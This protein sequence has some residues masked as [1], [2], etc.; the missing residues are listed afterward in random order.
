VAVYAYLHTPKAVSTKEDDIVAFWEKRIRRDGALSAYNA[1]A[2]SVS[3]VDASEAHRGAHL[4]GEALYAIQGV[5]GISTCDEQFMYGC[6]HQVV[7]EAILEDGP[8]VVYE[9]GKKC[10]GDLQCL[11]GIGHGVVMWYGYEQDMLTEAFEACS[12]AS[13]DNNFNGCVSGVFMEYNYPAFPQT[14]NTHLR[15][16]PPH[17][18]HEPCDTV[19]TE[20]APLCYYWQ[21]RLWKDSA[22]EEKDNTVIISTISQRCALLHDDRRRGCMGGIGP[23]TISLTAYNP[24]EITRLCNAIQGN[25]E[26]ITLCHAEAG[27]VL[28]GT[29]SK[30]A[31]QQLCGYLPYVSEQKRCVEYATTE[32]NPLTF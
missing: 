18:Y 10:A 22:L 17:N 24:K 5:G 21:V 2:D 9:L 8:R 20:H 28:I 26:E 3:E 4:F 7:A 11:H 15:P 14:K 16:I 27:K 23:S 1:F 13:P 25:R 30:E 32:S 29:V 31:M 6:L 12:K 19:P